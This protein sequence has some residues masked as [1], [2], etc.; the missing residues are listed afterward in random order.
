MKLSIIYLFYFFVRDNEVNM[1]KKI[2][3]DVSDKLNAT[4]SRDFDGMVGLSLI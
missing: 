3:R 1:I 2:T 4:S